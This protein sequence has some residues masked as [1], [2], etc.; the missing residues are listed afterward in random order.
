MKG[1]DRNKIRFTVGF[2]PSRR[3]A[4]TS[5]TARAAGAATPPSRADLVREAVGFT[6]STS[7]TWSARAKPLPET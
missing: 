1:R 2:T 5:S 4:W 7:P 6:S 3:A